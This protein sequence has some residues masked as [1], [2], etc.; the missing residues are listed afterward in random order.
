MT[1]KGRK[2]QSRR[3]IVVDPKSAPLSFRLAVKSRSAPL[4]LLLPT[5][6]TPL[7]SCWVPAL[8]ILPLKR[9]S[10]G[11]PRPPYWMYPPGC[12]TA[13]LP[14]PSAYSV[15]PPVLRRRGGLRLPATPPL[16]PKTKRALPMAAP[17]WRLY[18]VSAFVTGRKRL[19]R[20]RSG[21]ITKFFLI[22]FLT[23][24]RISTGR[25]RRGPCRPG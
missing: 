14:A 13:A 18:S 5:R 22:L 9:P 1:R 2:S 17:T 25:N 20:T 19:F 8:T 12:S 24:K 4:C 21:A 10:T 11:G 23:R 6:P 15:T 16:S 7:G 3:G